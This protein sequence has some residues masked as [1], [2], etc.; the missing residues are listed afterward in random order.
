VPK[1]QYF[2]VLLLVLFRHG[3]LAAQARA[4]WPR[5]FLNDAPNS[6]ERL[7]FLRDS[8]AHAPLFWR[9][10]TPRVAANSGVA[11]LDGRSA[12]SGFSISSIAFTTEFNSGY[13]TD[14]N[15]GSLWGGRGLNT[16][17]EGGIRY[18]GA[19]IS[20][21]LLPDINYQENREFETQPVAAGRNPFRNPFYANID[22]PQRF[23]NSSYVTAGLGQ[24]FARV[25]V[26]G[27]GAGVATENLW[28][29]PGLRE[30]IVLSN[31]AA[32]FPHAF[33]ESN[34]PVNVGLG[35]AR[36]S[37]FWG[38]LT[39]SEY[40]DTIPSN[41]HRLVS[42]AGLTF[43][44]AGAENLTIGFDRIFTYAW[45]SLSARNLVPFFAPVLKEQLTTPTNSKGN[46]AGDQR[47]SLFVDYRIPASGFEVYGEMGREDHSWDL[48]DLVGEPEHSAAYL[49]GF[50]RLAAL[51]AT[52]SIRVNGEWLNLQNLRSGSPARSTPVYYVHSPQG[53]TER[54]QI[55][56]AGIGPGA[57][58]Q[59]LGVDVL[60]EDHS[61][62]GFVE[63]VRRDETAGPAVES[64]Q[65]WPPK[66][67]VE[68]TGGMRGMLTVGP[69]EASAQLSVSRRLQRAFIEDATNARLVL[70]ARW[71]GNSETH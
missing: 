70:G 16:H 48:R 63:R 55:L 39:E 43:Q 14:R 35:T 41:D 36:I 66:H 62:G 34:R 32:G 1:K 8:S 31:T 11:L 65:T 5:L 52:R 57:E 44:P 71:I 24:S 60:S 4:D 51:S 64:R 15:N 45:D 29:G 17:L 30:S 50:Q 58:S 2:I 10:S 26:G 12:R 20:V 18:R 67:D 23:G 37:V 19:H 22:L 28:W 9:A 40:F 42:G 46:D 56:G 49:I 21:G 69:I 25:D 13:A 54:G 68:L 33:L 38:R 3:P 59:F 7:A 61:L 27:F 53:Y 47:L 6:V